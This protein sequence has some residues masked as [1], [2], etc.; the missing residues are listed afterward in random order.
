MRTLHTAR[1]FSKSL[2]CGVMYSVVAPETRPSLCP[3]LKV[4]GY[5]LD[6]SRRA[7]ALLP[8]PL[9]GRGSLNVKQMNATSSVCFLHFRLLINPH[10]TYRPTSGCRY[11]HG[12]IT[13]Q[14]TGATP[15]PPRNYLYRR[16]QQ[17]VVTTEGCLH[18]S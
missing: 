7:R 15:P 18:R 1:N 4:W 8:T 3:Y 9:R 10:T 12:Q 14:E 2:D 13:S 6:P 17:G 5:G 11:H 16:C